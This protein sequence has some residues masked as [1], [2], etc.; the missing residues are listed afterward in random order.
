[1]ESQVNIHTFDTKKE[2]EKKKVL[3][4][5]SNTSLWKKKYHFRDCFLKDNQQVIT[6]K[7]PEST[8]NTIYSRILNGINDTTENKQWHKKPAFTN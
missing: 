2:K 7:P 3:N 5:Y 8:V 1:M 4:E 6:F